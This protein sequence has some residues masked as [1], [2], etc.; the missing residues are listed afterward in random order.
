MSSIEIKLPAMEAEHSI[1]IEVRINGSTK[2]YNYRIEILKWDKCRQEQ[3]RAS[4]LKEM[5]AR[6][7]T[8]W[9]VIQIGG[10]TEKIVPVMFKKN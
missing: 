4:C 8:T 2:R 5:L 10:A 3:D 9:Q 1:E 6:Y 7:D